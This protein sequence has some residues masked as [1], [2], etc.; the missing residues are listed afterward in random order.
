MRARRY[1]RDRQP[2]HRFETYLDYYRLGLLRGP[3]DRYLDPFMATPTISLHRRRRSVTRWRSGSTT[4]RCR[5]GRAA[6][7]RKFSPT[8]RCEAFRRHLGHGPGDIV[9]CSLARLVLEK[10]LGMFAE[11]IGLLRKRD[12]QSGRW[13]L[14]E[15]R[16]WLAR[17]LSNVTYLGFLDGPALG[18]AVASTDILINQRHEAFG[19]VNL[20]AMAQDW[21]RF[22]R[23]RQRVGLD[24]P[25]PH[26]PAGGAGRRVCL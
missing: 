9:R 15:A 1:S 24:R 26:R 4:T 11:A 20:E 8:L 7:R 17:R 3:V 19:N 5:S 18:Q 2:A 12:M 13:W 23:C 21:R 6:S 10:G 14:A 22:G 16:D 25:W